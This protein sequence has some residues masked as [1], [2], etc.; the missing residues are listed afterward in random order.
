[1]QLGNFYVVSVTKTFKWQKKVKKFWMKKNQ[2]CPST[3]QTFILS[4]KKR[5]EGG[6]GVKEGLTVRLDL[7][8]APGRVKQTF[9]SQRKCLILFKLWKMKL[10]WFA[11]I[12]WPNTT[13][14]AF[15]EIVNFNFGKL[16]KVIQMFSRK[17]YVSLM[18]FFILVLQDTHLLSR[19]TCFKALYCCRWRFQFFDEQSFG[20]SRVLTSSIRSQT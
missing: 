7:L 17:H 4:K 16:K 14:N 9:S 15:L 18:L 10:R 5:L 1:M 13:L 19:C 8:W 2:L 3:L 6:R 12:I 20:V 11:I